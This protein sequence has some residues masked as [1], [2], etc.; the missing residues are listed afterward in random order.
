MRA[1]APFAVS[2]V[3]TSSAA[4]VGCPREDVTPQIEVSPGVD[5]RMGLL[6]RRTGT[7]TGQTGQGPAADAG[8]VAKARVHRLLK[9]QELAGKTAV[10][11]P[12]DLVLENDEVVF[13]ID[14]LGAGT[15]FAESGGNVIDAADAKTRVDELGLFFSYFGTFPRQ[16]VYDRLTFHEDSD[17]SATVEARGKELY[18]PS[19]AVVTKYKLGGG[20]RAILVSTDVTNTGKVAVTLPGV[21]DAVQWGFTEKLVP[22]KSK[23]FK[24][25][26]SAPFF[27]GIGREASY[28]L[29][30]TDGRIDGL[31][32]STWTDTEQD[33]NVSL[34]PGITKSYDRVLVVGERGDSAS[35]LAELVRASGGEVGA[36]SVGLVG[37]TSGRELPAPLGARISIRS[38]DDKEIADLVAAG[39]SR[40]EGELPPGKYLLAYAGGAGRRGAGAKIPITVARGKTSE[41]KVSVTDAGELAI[42]C[43]DEAGSGLPC[44]A[45]VVGENGTDTP[46]LGP[47]DQAG[48]A[49]N[50]IT[51]ATGKAQVPLA[52]GAYVVTLTRGPEYSAHVAHV[53]VKENVPTEVTGKLVRVVDTSGF[54]ACDFHQH[55]MLGSDSSVGKRDRVISNAAEG[56]EIAL[57]SEHNLVV[58]LSGIVKELSLSPF[59]VHLSG[60]EVTTDALPQPWG[61]LN[62]FPLEVDDTLPRG[63]AFSVRGKSAADIV[64][65]ARALPSRPV[66]QVNH[67]RSGSNGYFDLLKFDRAKARGEG[68]GYSAD[69]DALEIWNGREV[70][71][72]DKSLD[73]YFALLRAGRPVTPT[74][75]TDTHGIVGHEPG[76]PRTLV[77]VKSD[78]DLAS[79]SPARTA[80]LVSQLER[81]RDVVLTNGPFVTATIDG[82]MPGDLVSGHGKKQLSVKVHVEAPPYVDV[83]RVWLRTT[84]LTEVGKVELATSGTPVPANDAKD[85]SKKTRAAAALSCTPSVCKADLTIPFEVRGDEAVVVMAA[86]DRDLVELVEGAGPGVR[87]FAMTSAFFVDADGDGKALGR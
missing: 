9:G 8:K 17:G 47:R 50:R 36:I 62:L 46:D 42:T 10:G 6:P 63:G 23:G 64:A 74:G 34:P 13:V 41:A 57:T 59:L 68:A 83:R 18:E 1:W 75:N 85:A 12:G 87:P 49:R 3:A 4:L 84:R 30:G 27:A 53:L 26:A 52:P 48:P 45:T 76:Y 38:E 16:A 70:D 58:D 72:R 69:F 71:Q 61:H 51:T 86:G 39:T 55:T 19:L 7:G 35:V 5:K 29:T 20:D 33:T 25:R 24:G 21:G 60:N 14:Q 66:V 54:V 31:H 77:R 11:R 37:A 2:F 40:I 22:G 67:P 81:G 44:K 43:E 73:D 79:W 82:K 32:G 65:E 80:E 56:L 78:R 28:A 15:G